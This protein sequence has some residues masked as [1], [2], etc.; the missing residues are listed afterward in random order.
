MAIKVNARKG[1][2][3]WRWFHK[4]EFKFV[5]DVHFWSRQLHMNGNTSKWYEYSHRVVKCSH[6]GKVK[7]ITYDNGI[8]PIGGRDV[9]FQKIL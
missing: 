4:C 8:L 9:I 7:T 3:W 1:S 6:C 2:L 5:E